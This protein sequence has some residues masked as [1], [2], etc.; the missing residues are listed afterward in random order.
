[1]SQEDRVMFLRFCWGR[2]RLP[3]AGRWGNERKFKLSKLSK[4]GTNDATLPL[5]HSCFFNLELPDYS[6]QDIMRKRLLTAMN[7]SVGFYGIV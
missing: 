2:S 1:M 4:Q 3:A 5:A 6:T 7:Y